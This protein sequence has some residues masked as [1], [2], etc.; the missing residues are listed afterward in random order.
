[1]KARQDDKKA[2]ATA[3]VTVEA[4]MAELEALGTAQNRKVYRRHGAGDNQFGVSFANLNALRRRIKTDHA[5]ALG[6]WRTG[7]TDARV[8][9][10]MVADPKRL[11]AESAEVWLAESSYYVLVDALVKNLIAKS[12]YALKKLDT[13]TRSAE[14]WRGRAGWVLLALLAM[15]DATLEDDFFLPYLKTIEQKILTRPNRTRE[16]MNNALIAV[17]LRSPALKERA[18]AVA[19]VIGPVPV[20]HGETSCRTPAAAD[21]IH[22][23]WERKRAKANRGGGRLR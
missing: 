11:S 8:L 2:A 4:V 14:E 22:K 15:E 21:Y 3:A 9:A 17:G 10:T 12:P 18:L 5:L 19:G 6:L 1:M 7:N 16:A 13:W 20:D 23:S